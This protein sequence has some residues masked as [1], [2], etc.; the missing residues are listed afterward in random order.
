MTEFMYQIEDLLNDEE[1]KRYIE[2]FDDPNNV[3]SINDKH[4]KY[5]RVQFQDEELAS[6]L[7]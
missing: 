2:M 7:Y 5:N 6:Q 1:C 4:R 3:E